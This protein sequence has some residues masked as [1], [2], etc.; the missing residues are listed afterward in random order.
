[1]KILIFL[2]I[3]SALAIQTKAAEMTYWYEKPTNPENGEFVSQPGSLSSFSEIG[4]T[5]QYEMNFSFKSENFLKYAGWMTEIVKIS[6]KMDLNFDSLK[7]IQ[8]TGGL[9]KSKSK[10]T[11]SN[12]ATEM[13]DIKCVNEN[14]SGLSFVCFFEDTSSSFSFRANEV[15]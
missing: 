5:I 8:N 10:L 7:Q 1:M 6:G 12:G 9:L 4:S 2:T 14:D 11:Y 3:F 15:K 13:H